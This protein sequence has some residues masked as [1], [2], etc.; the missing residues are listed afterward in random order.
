MGS[1]PIQLDLRIAQIVVLK[2]LLQVYKLE[3]IL[4][5]TPTGDRMSRQKFTAALA[6]SDIDD[7]GF[8]SRNV[9]TMTRIFEGSLEECDAAFEAFS[10]MAIAAG[11]PLVIVK[12]L[13]VPKK[14]ILQKITLITLS[15]NV[16]TND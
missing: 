15:L 16:T 9:T 11:F 1:I 2:T 3:H 13:V 5:P 12:V 14:Q 6:H 7:I 8:D 4:L 10:K